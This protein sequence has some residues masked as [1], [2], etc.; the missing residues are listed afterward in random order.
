MKSN[1]P[2][3]LAAMVVA[4]MLGPGCGPERRSSV[5]E[6]EV[7]IECDASLLPVAQ[8]LVDDFQRTYEKA[9]IHLRSVEAREAITNFV[10]DSVYYIITAREFND[11]EKKYIAAVN[12]EQQGYLVAKDAVVVIGNKQNPIKDLRVSLVDS[13]YTGLYTRWEWKKANNL[14]DPV[15]GDVNSST[16]EVF[17]NRVLSGKPFASSVTV[18]STSEKLIQF[19]KDNP[20]AIGIV[21][22]SWLQGNE[23]E[24]RIFA[25]GTPGARPDSTEPEGRYYPPVQAHVYRGYYPITRPVY[26][27][28]RQI[29]RDVGYGFISYVA[30]PAGQKLFLNHGLVPAT[31]PVRL[32]ELTSKEV[33]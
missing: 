1:L 27:Y 6:G 20:N 3:L 14:V 30:G 33:R 32:V 4:M 21:G 8:V 16:N 17:R 25:L 11:E 13:I 10:N 22:L 24:L 28:T 26:I 9:K 19:V 15:A 23:D 7:T 31:M 2:Y 5:T 29:V 12:I 18:F